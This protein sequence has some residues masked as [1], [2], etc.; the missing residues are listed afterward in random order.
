VT[1][2]SSKPVQVLHVLFHFAISILYVFGHSLLLFAQVITLN[3]SVNSDNSSLF[4]VLVS[5][6]FI[7]LKGAVFKRFDHH[8]LM[9]ISASDIVERF[10]LTIFLI[11]I[12]IQNLAHIGLAFADDW[13]EKAGFMCLMVLGGEWVVDWIKHGFITKFNG[14]PPVVYRHFAKVLCTDYIHTHKHK[15]ESTSIHSVSR[16]LGLPSIPIAVLVVRV[17][18]QAFLHSPS[19][20]LLKSGLLLVSFACLLLLKCLLSIVL[21]GHAAKR[22]IVEPLEREK[23][24]AFAAGLSANAHIHVRTKREHSPYT[25]ILPKSPPIATQSAAPSHVPLG[26]PPLPQKSASP[27][28]FFE[29]RVSTP[30]KFLG[31]PTMMETPTTTIVSSTQCSPSLLGLREPSVKSASMLHLSP[32]ALEQPMMSTVGGS[33]RA[34]RMGTPLSMRSPQT[35]P[36]DTSFPRSQELSALPIEPAFVRHSPTPP[37][38]AA[39]AAEDGPQLSVSITD[40]DGSA[41]VTED[42]LTARFGRIH[43]PTALERFSSSMS[44]EPF[45][46]QVQTQTVT[47]QLDNTHQHH[48]GTIIPTAVFSSNDSDDTSSVTSDSAA[49]GGHFMGAWPSN[50]GVQPVELMRQ[51]SAESTASGTTQS[52]SVTSS[53]VDAVEI[54]QIPQSVGSA[55]GDGATSTPSITAVHIYHHQVPPPVSASGAS[56]GQDGSG[57]ASGTTSVGG[58]GAA[59]GEPQQPVSYP[60]T[61]VTISSAPKEKAPP[62]YEDE[63]KIEQDLLTVQRYAISANKAIPV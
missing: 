33:A 38:Q 50:P 27:P 53:T 57:H 4:V 51:T 47:L 30:T 22:V 41:T 19:H 37:A 25:A 28:P 8:N 36:K 15:T 54:V 1:H 9:Q 35:T 16:R 52:I 43:T 59:S 63:S 5:N 46:P 48:G 60:P 39:G 17:V 40:A 45:T 29:K 6:N 55:Q 61:V 56:Q 18:Y 42:S 11:V 20:I 62:A 34:S 7:E 21:L 26:L 49:G 58:S 31:A 44:P 10:Q 24:E 14:I 32:L 13:L 23:H 12:M 3:V 2:I